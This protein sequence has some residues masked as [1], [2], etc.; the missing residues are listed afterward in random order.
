MSERK[1][2]QWVERFQK[3]QTS[4]TDEHSLIA[5]TLMGPMLYADEINSVTH[6]QESTYC[7][8]AS[9]LHSVLLL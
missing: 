6:M 9:N 4:V 7:K 1:V 3:Y 8:Q 2:Y 5:R